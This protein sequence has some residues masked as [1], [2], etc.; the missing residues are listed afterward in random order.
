VWR[1]KGRLR[2]KGSFADP[3]NPGKTDFLIV[4]K[5]VLG[6]PDSGTRVSSSREQADTFGSRDDGL[7]I[8]G[9]LTN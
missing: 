4:V 3:I 6:W 1:P 2:G 8:W 9:S 7:G 5:V